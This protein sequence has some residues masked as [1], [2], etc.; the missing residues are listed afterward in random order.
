MVVKRHVLNVHMT[1]D[2][3]FGFG[4][5]TGH[6]IRSA[7]INNMVKQSG[8]G[9]IACDRC[10]NSDC[11][12]KHTLMKKCDGNGKIFMNPMYIESE[13][14]GKKDYIATTSL[15][16]KII[17]LGEA[18]EH[19]DAVKKAVEKMEFNSD[20]LK[21][22]FRLV[23]LEEETEEIVV[24]IKDNKCKSVKI[25]F[26]TPYIYKPAATNKFKKEV[27][28]VR[29]DKLDFNSLMRTCTTRVTALMNSC[30][31]GEHFDYRRFTDKKYDVK[32]VDSNLHEDVFVRH[33]S[34][35]DKDEYIRALSGYV[36]YEGDI[37]EACGLLELVSRLNIGKETTLGFGKIICERRE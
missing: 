11:V 1:S 2:K 36:V 28:P 22:T 25:T 7:L 19:L 10:N 8:C 3:Y 13:F 30:C 17:L 34:R 14:V 23:G 37:N 4:K 20:G 21:G 15:D 32:I 35:R 24:D 5:F 31:D 12:L 26:E 9:S 27:G 6:L 18:I 29:R 16:F 33:S